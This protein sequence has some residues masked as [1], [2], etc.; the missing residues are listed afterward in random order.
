MGNLS[1]CG[2]GTFYYLLCQQCR[3]RY[4]AE[5]PDLKHKS[6]GQSTGHRAAEEDLPYARLL[7][8]A[9]DLLG[10]PGGLERCK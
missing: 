9:P 4:L 8:L 10:P 5:R 1:Q 7:H 3:Q 6:G 2:S